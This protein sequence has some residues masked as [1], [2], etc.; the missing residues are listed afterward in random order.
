MDKPITLQLHH[1]DGNPTN[2]SLNNLQLLCPNCHSQ[3]E[4]YCGKA[5]NNPKKYYCK[6]CG[7]EITRTATYCS[8]CAKKYRRKVINRPNVDQL[9]QDFKDLKSFTK[10]GKKYNVSD[11]TIRK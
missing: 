2:N 1:I 9:I 11:Q 8:N 10:V 7:K 5:N 6:S 4:N 3:T